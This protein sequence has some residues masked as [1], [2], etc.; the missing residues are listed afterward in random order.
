M[1]FTFAAITFVSKP[2]S[3]RTPEELLWLPRICTATAKTKCLEAHRLESHITYKNKKIGPGNPAPIFLFDGP[4]K[5]ARLVQVGVVRPT[6]QR[7]EALLTAAGAAATIRNTICA[8]A[9]PGQSDEQTAIMAEVRGP[10]VL[11]VR[12]Q[13]VQIFDHGIQVELFKLFRIIEILAHRIG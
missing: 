6:V 4:Q 13:R 11:G 3:F 10:P 5:S 1:K 2:R 12:H 7:S 8:R 9:V